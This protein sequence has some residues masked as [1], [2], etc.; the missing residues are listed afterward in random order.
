MKT[1]TK[2]PITP[3]DLYRFNIITDMELSPNG[4][5]VVFSVQETDR[6]SEKKYAHLWIAPV[7]G[8]QPYQFTF[9]KQVNSKPHW[10]PDGKTIAFLSNRQDEKQFQ[11]YLLPFSG[12]EAHQLTALKGEFNN[13]YW[14]PNRKTLLCE[15]RKKDRE[16]I[17]RESDEKKKELGIVSRRITRVFFKLD[18][19]GYL[20]QE[21]WHL[22]TI[23][24]ATGKAVQLTDS[25]VFDDL[26]SSWSP[27][28]KEIVF[29]SN[30]SDSPDLNPDA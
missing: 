22:W 30:H 27:D 7:N 9:G 14:S 17:N 21:R 8:K 10:S 24:T 19:Y 26:Q 29:V 11:I 12:G 4:E 6:D 23:N 18:A 3:Q 20:P 1:K 16:A 13:F 2:R 5:H 28:G 25:K 15:F